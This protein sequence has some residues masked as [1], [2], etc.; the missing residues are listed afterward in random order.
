MG[1][2]ATFGALLPPPPPEQATSAN[3]IDTATARERNRVTIC[4]LAKTSG[5]LAERMLKSER[6]ADMGKAESVF[7][8]FAR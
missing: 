6:A 1:A 3:A 7:E 2:I 5:T 8:S 4:I